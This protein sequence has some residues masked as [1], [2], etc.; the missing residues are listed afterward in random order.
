MSNKDKDRIVNETEPATGDLYVEESTPE[1]LK[2]IKIEPEKHSTIKF[3]NGLIV[4]GTINSIIKFE[5]KP[6][7]ITLNNASV[8]LKNDVLFKPDWG[9][10]DLACGNKIVSIYGGPADWINYQK[11]ELTKKDI[12]YHSSN[13]TE[14]TEYLNKLYGK[15]ENLRNE[16]AA[17]E[18]Y[19]TIL[20]IVYKKYDKEWL[21]CMIIYEIIYK[22]QTIRNEVQFLKNHLIKFKSDLQ[23][24]NAIERGLELIEEDFSL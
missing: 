5:G 24:K 16:K 11:L 1:E 15:V 13:L 12:S 22:D 23:L 10:Y 14:D 8:R 19:I 4:S 18:D 17:S 3:Y 21:L 7:L 20:K 9:Q 6:I 2:T